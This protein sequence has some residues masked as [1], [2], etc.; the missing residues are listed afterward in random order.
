V[1]KSRK[2]SGNTE[3]KRRLPANKKLNQ[4][5]SVLR[6]RVKGLEKKLHKNNTA[7][8]RAVSRLLLKTLE[9]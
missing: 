3:K 9:R 4:E 8:R 1:H 5:M 2:L 6:D 7:G